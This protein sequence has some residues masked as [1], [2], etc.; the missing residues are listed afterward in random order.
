LQNGDPTPVDAAKT[1]V[2]GSGV[3]GLPREG[4]HIIHQ[5]QSTALLTADISFLYASTGADGTWF[6]GKAKVCRR[7]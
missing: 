7:Q 5:T 6:I 2:S 1:Y 3:L 4:W